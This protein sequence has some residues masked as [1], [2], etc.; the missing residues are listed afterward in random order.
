MGRHGIAILSARE[1]LQFVPPPTSDCGPLLELVKALRDAGVR[2]RAL[3]DAT[4]GGVTAVLHE[5][6]RD[7]GKTLV[8]DETLVPFSDEVRGV[9]ELLVSIP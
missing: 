2:P 1:Q 4:R 6:A 7:C 8:I 5:W 9:C 3:R